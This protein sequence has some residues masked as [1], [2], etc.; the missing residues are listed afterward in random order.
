MVSGR[1]T[2]R[3]PTESGDAI[4]AWVYPG[5]GEGDRPAVVM[6]HGMG[7]VK[8]GGLEPFAARFQAAGFTA[9]AFDYRH[10]GGSGGLPRD[11]LSVPRQRDDYRSVI[12]WARGHDSIDPGRIFVW[13][14]SFS[15]LHAVELAATDHRL[16]GVIAQV[17]L[18][19]GFSTVG[20]T[21]KKHLA[22]LVGLGLLDR[23]GAAFGRPPRYL[24]VSGAP[25]SLA[26]TATEDA[27]AGMKLIATEDD[28]LW[29]N[30]IAARSVLGIA[31]H[32]PVKKAGRIAIPILL[33]VAR[34]DSVAPT[35]MAVDVAEKAPHGELY[36]SRGGHYDVY[37]GGEAYEDAVE[38]EIE[39][40]L[41]IVRTARG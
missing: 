30:Q 4:E 6:A 23:I 13:G 2:V 21:P 34:E 3:I 28:L 36:R 29:R 5:A 41:R 17:P 18:V 16:A 27:L 9:I 14:T 24:P 11:V 8:A 32:R 1:S 37:Q 38:A 31:R 40:L 26:V 25:G 20:T 15:G 7:G 19:D 10:W 12:A 35:S 39:F 33:V 22:R